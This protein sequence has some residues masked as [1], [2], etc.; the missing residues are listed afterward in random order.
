MPRRRREADRAPQTTT[1][2]TWCCRTIRAPC[3]GSRRSRRSADQI[4]HDIVTA[5]GAT[6]LGADDKAGVAEIVTAARASRR[7]SGDPARADPD[8]VHA[9]RRDRPRHEA[10]RRRARS[11]PSAPT[12]STAAAR[13]EI[14]IESF[15]ADAMTVTF[16]GFNT[17]PG[18]ARAGWSTRSRSAAS[19]IDRAAARTRCRRRRPTATK[20]SSTRTSMQRAASDQTSVQLLVRDFVTAALKEKEALLERLAR[21]ATAALSRRARR[22]RRRG[23]SAQHARGARPAP[24]RSSNARARRSAAPASEPHSSSRSAA[25]PTARASRSWA[26]RRRTSSPASTTSTRGSSG[27]RCRTWRRRSR[28]SF[29]SQPV[30]RGVTL[31]GIRDSGFGDTIDAGSTIAS[32]TNPD[33]QLLR[34]A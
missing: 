8:R 29:T 23:V 7:A 31:L 16:H 28:S 24:G 13:G 18:Y 19:F 26:C 10:L 6:L 14:E 12:R 3:C 4:G 1:A 34:T 32:L 11:A 22:G 21:G 2:A 20:A 30:G 25:A 33:H 17:H 27:C 15:S 9:G 5:S